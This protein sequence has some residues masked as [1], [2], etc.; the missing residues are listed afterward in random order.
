[1]ALGRTGSPHPPRI[2]RRIVRL[3]CFL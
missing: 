2:T 1:L 3:L